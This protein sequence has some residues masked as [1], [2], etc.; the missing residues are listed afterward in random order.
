MTARAGGERP[1]RAAPS[2]EPAL[3]PGP[4]TPQ[5]LGRQLRRLIGPLRGRRLC[6]AYSG[7]MDS[8]ALLAA[9]ALLRPT[10][11]FRLRALHV[12]HGLHPES[13]AWAA[14]ACAQA[15]RRHVRCE[16]IRV[17]IEGRGDSLEARARRE[18]YR[19]LL[20]ALRADEVLLTAHH[21][22][23]QLETMLLALARGSGVRGL[24]AIRAVTP[25]GATL[26]L[27][28]LLPVAR[29]A[30]ERFVRRRRLSFSVDPSNQDERFDRNLVR[31]RVLPPLLAR[32]PA[33]AVTAARSASHL[34]EAQAL[35]DQQAAGLIAAAADGRG[36][37]ASVL[38]RWP[39]PVRGQALRHWLAA[40]ALPR[41]DHRRLQ[42][43]AGPLLAAR[44][45][46]LPC[47]RWPGAV[48]RRHG[49]RLLAT[50]ERG[51]AAA[52]PITAWDW[53]AQRQLPLGEGAL[54]LVP[55]P[56]GNIDMAILPCPLQVRY[57]RGGERL[58]GTQG[59]IALK[60]LLQSLRVEPWERARV[61]LLVHSQRIIAVADLWLDAACRAGPASGARARLRW[62]RADD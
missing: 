44:S 20:A 7:G 26:L 22:E 25:F 12:D 41:P 17:R 1:R 32:W 38:R 54:R 50:A 59:R 8:T 14:A 62:H 27:R 60:D 45:D 5:W 58:A 42:E 55:D 46:A 16:A 30:L 2:P 34:A 3:D 52:P 36:L 11:G 15:R 47:V 53:R 35:L 49:D 13:A 9:L 29:A 37:R 48:V 33:L 40:R 18:R 43:L 23:D 4:F 39:L 51:V 6:L 61:P 28:P 19:A 31:L 57:R 56:H 21:R 10:A 24:A